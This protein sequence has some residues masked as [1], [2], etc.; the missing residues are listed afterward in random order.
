[1]RLLLTERVFDGDP[2]PWE[3]THIVGFKR[4]V[5]PSPL[6]QGETTRHTSI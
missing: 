3:W 1:M 5:H 2:G 6:G 4:H